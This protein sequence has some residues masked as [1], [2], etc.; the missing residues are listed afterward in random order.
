MSDYN[1]NMNKIA[2]TAQERTTHLMVAITG[3]IAVEMGWRGGLGTEYKALIRKE[4][5]YELN[6]LHAALLEF[7]GKHP[8]DTS[9]DET[10][11]TERSE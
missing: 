1:E 6:A 8:F 3:R 7:F 5:S 2:A 9:M 10:H 4:L 11:D